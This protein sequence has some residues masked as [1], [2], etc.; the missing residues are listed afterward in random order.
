MR[1]CLLLELLTSEDVNLELPAA[2]LPPEGEL[3]RE[4]EAITPDKELE[5][6]LLLK[7]SS[8]LLDPAT[9]EVSDLPPGLFLPL[10]Q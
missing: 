2:I 9:Y 5:R 7:T 3:S 1:S 4:S 10:N 6:E 8:E